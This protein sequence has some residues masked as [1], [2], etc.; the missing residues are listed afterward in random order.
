MTFLFGPP[1]RNLEA[2]KQVAFKGSSLRVFKAGPWDLYWIGNAK[3]G[4]GMAIFPNADAVEGPMAKDASATGIPLSTLSGANNFRGGIDIT[5][6]EA[7]A[8]CIEGNARILEWR[9]ST[10][11]VGTP[12]CY[13]GKPGL[14]MHYAFAFERKSMNPSSAACGK[15]MAALEKTAFAALKCKGD[16]EPTAY[17][18]YA[19]WS[20]SEL[21]GETLQ[22]IWNVAMDF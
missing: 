10:R 17:A 7:Q 13:Y 19:D 22:A 4:E 1:V 6:A 15:E 21:A 18:M 11:A 3:G 12:N 9:T 20:A 5:F 8:A 16:W 14:Y 2:P